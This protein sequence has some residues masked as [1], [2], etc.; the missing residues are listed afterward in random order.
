MFT[1][2]RLKAHASFIERVLYFLISHSNEH[3]L[4]MTSFY[5]QRN[6]II[7][8]ILKVSCLIFSIQNLHLDLE[9]WQMEITA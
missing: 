5:F 2:Q 7:Y 1:V 9:R 8:A 6:I 4:H 3:R